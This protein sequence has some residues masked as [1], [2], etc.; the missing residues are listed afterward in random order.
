[1][2]REMFCIKCNKPAFANGNFCKD[3]LAKQYDL[4]R[5][6]STTA[7]SC[8]NCNMYEVKG[9]K[10]QEFASDDDAA[11]HI[12]KES[13]E[14]AGEIKKI[15]TRMRKAGN[16]YYVEL[17]CTGFLSIPYL[18]ERLEKT[19]KREMIIK[20]RKI[21]CDVCAK[22]SG[23]YFEA[24]LQLRG[25]KQNELLETVKKL[26][27]PR[28]ITKIETKREG[29]DVYMTFKKDAKRVVSLLKKRRAMTSLKK[30]YKFKGEKKTVKLYRD[31]YAIR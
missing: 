13:I 14:S 7:K 23:N 21:K 2:T 3:C 8:S 31:Y 6:Q 10:W 20:F 19:E 28:T 16:V 18:D 4:F 26:A 12:A 5:I 22:V 9:G 1:M 24:I 30:S 15:S 17:T 11:L 29:H 27:G 25:E